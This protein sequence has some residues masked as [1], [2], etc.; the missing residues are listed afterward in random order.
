MVTSK[1]GFGEIHSVNEKNYTAVVK[2]N[3]DDGI[4]TGDLQI[5]APITLNNK[6]SQLPDVGTPCVVL[7]FSDG[8]ERGVVLGGRYSDENTCD[9]SKGKKIINYQKS[10]ITISETGVIKIEALEMSIKSK[11]IK[12]DSEE[13]NI[14]SKNLKIKSDE[15]KIT[16]KIVLDGETTVNGD[17]ALNKNLST[18]SG[19]SVDESGQ[20]TTGN[21][22]KAKDFIK[23]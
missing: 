14:N 21:I 2:L 16:G 13:I 11:T 4:L 7:M 17:L 19:V 9:L 22:I 10:K 12:I 20:M 15:T 5:V 3:E 6:E 1:I 8:N 23:I 18:S